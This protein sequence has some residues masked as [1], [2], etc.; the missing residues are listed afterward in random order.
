VPALL[1]SMH[2][3]NKTAPTLDAI[4]SGQGRAFEDGYSVATGAC[5]LVVWFLFGQYW[6]VVLSEEVFE[7][8]RRWDPA[9]AES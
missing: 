5:G 9:R 8:A 7:M 6:C 1:E 4:D 2:V 3:F